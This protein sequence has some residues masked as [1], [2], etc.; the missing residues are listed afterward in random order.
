[1][2]FT[3]V[4]YQTNPATITLTQSGQPVRIEPDYATKTVAVYI[5][6]AYVGSWHCHTAAKQAL[7]LVDVPAKRAK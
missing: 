7:N 3:A 6:G 4:S 2:E 1:L 5:A